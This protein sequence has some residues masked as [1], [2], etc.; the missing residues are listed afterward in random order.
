MLIHT[1]LI[2]MNF[3]AAAEYHPSLSRSFLTGNMNRMDVGT[4]CEFLLQPSNLY[5]LVTFCIGRRRLN[6]RNGRL[7]GSLICYEFLNIFKRF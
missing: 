2:Y 4:S 7:L 1:V 3:I 6:R 5:I